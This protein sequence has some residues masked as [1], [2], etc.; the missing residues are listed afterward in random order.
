MSLRTVIDAVFVFALSSTGT[1]ALGQPAFFEPT[2]GFYKARGARVT[3]TWSIDREE[4]PEDG[5]VTATLTIRGAANPREIVRPDLAKL[6]D[7]DGRLPYA[8]R[9]QIE[10]VPGALAPD[11]K[12]VTFVYRLRP[13]NREV[14]KLPSLEFWYD[15]GKKAGN[16]FQKT[17]AKGPRLVV[18]AA[19]RPAP[20]PVPLAEPERFFEIQTGSRVLDP[21]PFVAG[22]RLWVF[23]FLGG[24]LAAGA[25]Y[26]VWRH[27]YPEGARL[28]RLRRS[29]AVR[30][31]ADGIRR[32][33]R[34]ADP[35]GAI[36]T[37]VGGYLRARFPI[38]TGAET[39]GEIGASLNELFVRSRGDGAAKPMAALQ[40]N[41]I[42]EVVGFLR[43]CDEARFA[44][45]RDNSLSLAEEAQAMLMRLEAME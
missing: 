17:W 21:E 11:A 35:A 27:V 19:V 2:Q 26:F 30:R 9:F 31:A 24:A 8:E 28:A 43:R 32:A 13:R 23:L 14:D 15:T 16:P 6:R 3:A 18:T 39:P 33:A 7:S 12:E 36:A 1:A 41:R 44:S 4:V 29:R 25:W 40:P 38:P 5:T 10:N 22:R 42:D 45:I 34:T 37:A 20:P